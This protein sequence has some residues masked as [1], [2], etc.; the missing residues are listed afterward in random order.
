[1]PLQQFRSG[2]LTCVW[3]ENLVLRP[4]Q[5]LARVYGALEQ[6]FAFEKIRGKIFKP[7]S[8]NFNRTDLSATPRD[9]VFRWRTQADAS[10]IATTRAILQ[11][12]GVDALYDA[13]DLP[14][15][16]FGESM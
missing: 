6:P 12:L 9:I 8:T 16:A 2:G 5:E 10:Q 7:S 13:D 15:T 3:Y 11:A 1:M 14:G 4:E